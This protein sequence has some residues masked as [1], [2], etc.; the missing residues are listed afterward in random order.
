[1]V[2]CFFDEI[3]DISNWE[4]FIARLLRSEKCRIYLTG[5]SATMLSK[6]IA[7]QLRGRSLAWELFPFSFAEFL[8]HRGIHP[9]DGT[10][11]ERHLVQH[12]FEEYREKGGFPEI[13]D[14]SKKL[15]IMTHQEYYKSILLRDVVERHDAPHPQAVADLAARLISNAGALY[16][17]NRLQEYLRSVGHGLTKDFVHNCV[18][19]FE[20]AFFLFSVRMYTPSLARQNTNPKKIYCVDHGMLPSLNPSILA[21]RGHILENMVFSHLRR[22]TQEIYYYKTNA[23]NEVDFLWIDATGRKR[24]L[25]VCH[26]ISAPDTRKRELAGLTQAMRE[27]GLSESEIVTDRTAE[28]VKNSGQAIHIIPIW[29]WLLDK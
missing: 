10:S 22:N 18:Q 17:L 9:K 14:F 29:K 4:L 13:F 26:D 2:H 12:A 21:N 7:T 5:S 8:A 15:R 19:W 24:L 1:V 27:L 28:T 3:Q 25:Q 6:E 20:D 23:G 16:S 11:K